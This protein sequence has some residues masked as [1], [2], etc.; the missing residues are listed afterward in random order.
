[1]EAKQ[2]LTVEGYKFKTEEDA[3]LAKLE[4]QKI[5]Y[6]EK[7][8]NYERPEQ[9]LTVYKKALEEKAFQTPI[10]IRYLEKLHDYLEEN[11]EIT[12]PVLPI[13]MH[14][15]FSRKLR[16]TTNPARSRIKPIKQMDILKARY[17]NSVLLNIVLLLMVAVMFYIAL[18]S[19]SPNIINY[20]QTITNK[21]AEWEQEL[22]ERE[23]QV[24]QQEKEL[25]EAGID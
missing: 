13:P 14:T 4:S 15:N 21:Y 12:E 23:K 20:E 2:I 5:R 6:I 11:G 10:G 7:R 8:M 1:M 25:E 18:K 17:R 22:T 3:K 24:R 19:D 16:E 9:V